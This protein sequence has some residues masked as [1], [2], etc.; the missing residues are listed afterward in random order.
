MFLLFSTY[1]LY[2]IKIYT[3]IILIYHNTPLISTNNHYHFYKSI[4]SYQTDS[5]SKTLFHICRSYDCTLHFSQ[6]NN[7]NSDIA[8]ILCYSHTHKT[9]FSDKSSSLFSSQVFPSC[10]SALHFTQNAFA[11]FLQ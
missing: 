11:H 6:Y 8:G 3:N 9:S 4:D 10:H 5:Y 2:M 7:Y 1:S